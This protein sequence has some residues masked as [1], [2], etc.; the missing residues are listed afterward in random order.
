[1]LR[2]FIGRCARQFLLIHLIGLPLRPSLA[3]TLPAFP[4]SVNEATDTLTMD[5]RIP[6][7][8]SR[9][10]ERA[11]KANDQFKECNGCLEMIVVPV[12]EFVMGS[13]E[14]EEG[15]EEDESPQHK[16]RFVAPFAVGRFAITFD[17]WEA[18]VA[19]HGCKNYLPG[20]KGWGRGR[21]RMDRRGLVL[22][23][24]GEWFAA[25]T[26]IPRRGR[27]APHRGADWRPL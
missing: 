3:E 7:P 22:I 10:E 17:E 5:M 27:C 18:C 8:L 12:G 11:L 4:A 6:K 23:A 15:R 9:A 16:V 26:G 2:L 1:M 25:V 20:D 19:D 14:R 24:T 21:R 13:P